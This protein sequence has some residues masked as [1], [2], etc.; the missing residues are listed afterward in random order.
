MNTRFQW[1]VA[2]IVTLLVVL[3]GWS[4]ARGEED[5]YTRVGFVPLDG[6]GDGEL[7]AW[8]MAVSYLASGKA[9]AGIDDL[10]AMKPRVLA[11]H[12]GALGKKTSDL[13]DRETLRAAG[14]RAGMRWMVWGSIRREGKGVVVLASLLDVGSGKDRRFLNERLTKEQV[15]DLPALVTSKLAEAL[16]KKYKPRKGPR[17][18]NRTEALTLL[19]KGEDARCRASASNGDGEEQIW[20]E[21]GQWYEKAVKADTESPVAL[22]LLAGSLL[23]LGDYDARVKDKL[24]ARTEKLLLK[25]IE[26][27][28]KYAAAYKQLGSVLDDKGDPAGATKACVKAIELDPKCIGA[29][30]LIGIIL[31]K[32]GDLDG[33]IEAYDKAIELDPT[34]AA[35]YANL[36]NALDK[37]GDLDGALKSYRK[38]IELDPTLGKAY[39]CLGNALRDKGDPDGA[40]EAH[41][42]AIELE[43]KLAVAYYNLGNALKR[44]GDLDGAIEAQKK[45]IEVDPKF[46]VAY[47][48][49]GNALDDKGDLDGAIEA[50]EKAIELNP[51][52]ATAYTILGIVL[53]KKGDLDGAIEAYEKA[54]ELNPKRAET[55]TCL[56]NALSDKDDFDGAIE[57]HKKAIELDPKFALAYN[58]LGVALEKKGDRDKAIE[59]YDKAI[60]AYEKAIELDPKLAM[61]RKN[62]ERASRARRDLAALAPKPWY[63]TFRGLMAVM[64]VVV[65]IGAVVT[66][67]AGI[68]LWFR[69]RGKWR[70]VVRRSALYKDVSVFIAYLLMAGLGAWILL[71][72]VNEDGGG[73]VSLPARIFQIVGVLFSAMCLIVPI[74]MTVRAFL[75]V[76]WCPPVLDREADRVMRGQKVLCPLSRAV[77]LLITIEVRGSGRRARTIRDL[78]LILDDGTKVDI[79]RD[80]LVNLRPLHRFLAIEIVNQD[81]VVLWNGKGEI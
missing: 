13:S 60:E 80:V 67:L 66:L 64:V 54:I 40:I 4:E 56:G 27:D 47:C 71:L 39:V 73:A 21:A 33:A 68:S 34:W 16:G 62:L 23:V 9:Q 70:F 24:V 74:A 59:A 35:A 7:A 63:R 31:K 18:V 50:C 57:A 76:T 14:K 53:R 78:D 1:F 17:E 48:N 43:P 36:G 65:A 46:A 61:A 3:A 32:K 12:A 8:G 19:G 58:N 5:A 55:H 45:A 6:G 81:G 30:N 42:K 37:K 44:Q 11:Q 28:P 2:G 29:H 22:N 15:L 69:Y 26:M 72:I 75:P 20:K 77:R 38:A 10:V 51:K 25:A 79:G 41:K 52:F 49:L